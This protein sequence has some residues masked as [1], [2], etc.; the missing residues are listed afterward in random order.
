[1]P[2]DAAHARED[3]AGHEERQQVGQGFQEE[4]VVNGDQEVLVAAE[5][6]PTEMVH[7]V[8]VEGD[9]V[10]QVQLAQGAAAR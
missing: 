1:M 8:G 4:A 10:L 6:V 5:R 3:L 2:A 7:G 9:L